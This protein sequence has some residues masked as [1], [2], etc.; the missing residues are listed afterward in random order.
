MEEGAWEVASGRGKRRGGTPKPGGAAPHGARGGGGVARAP[1]ATAADAGADSPVLWQTTGAL[2]VILDNHLRRLA[3]T[4][5]RVVVVE[6]VARWLT[7]VRGAARRGAAALQPPPRL[8]ILGL[9]SI[10]SAS[11][12]SNPVL[13][14]AVAEFLRRVT[15]RAWEA[16]AAAEGSAGEE[17]AAE[18]L[19]AGAPALSAEALA[20]APWGEPIVRGAAV[21]GEGGAQ[22]LAVARDPAFGGADCSL[23]EGLGF[24]VATAAPRARRDA[25]SRPAKPVASA[26]AGSVAA[27]AA[28]DA[29]A[30]A[31]S[32]ASV[33]PSGASVLPSGASVLP[34]GASVLLPAAE[35]AAGSAD[36]SASSVLP[37]YVRIPGW[38]DGLEDVDEGEGGAEG[39]AGASA[40]E[41][42]PAGSA[43]AG[44]KPHAALRQ[45]PILFF[46]PHCPARLYASLL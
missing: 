41:P 16:L 30:A 44:A 7:R 11:A 39:G 35:A 8:E 38:D 37:W 15:V 29:A 5:A 28:A 10:A 9:G 2:R 34:S 12:T 17:R 36:P 33:L 13:Q 26:G 24:A 1:L 32:G 25:G 40:S 22:L 31:P 27:A 4:P 19:D 46:L 3:Y 18:G 45:P 43:G 21:A 23:L 14:L 6:S 20:T 42:S